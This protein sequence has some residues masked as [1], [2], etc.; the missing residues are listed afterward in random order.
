MKGTYV[1]CLFKINLKYFKDIKKELIDKGYY[2]VRVYVPTVSVL[3]K[4]TKGKDVYEDIPLL[5][6]YGFIKLKREDAF[7]KAFLKK[8]KDDIQ[9]IFGWVNSLTP[10]HRKRL[11]KRID[12]E[13][14]DDYSVVATVANSEVARFKRISKKN[15]V[16]HPDEVTSLKIGDYI[17]LKGY[18]FEGI[19]AT[20]LDV[21]LTTKKVSVRLYPG[22]ILAKLPFDNVI[23]S[24]YHNYDENKLLSN[25]NQQVNDI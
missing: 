2:S 5:F 4:R 11:R 24:I 14:F 19:E 8:L 6:T 17:V 9:G 21:N 16:Y 13:F 18:P 7:S 1:W 15:K 23:Y 3:K 20:V 25:N 10:L 12:P 22:D